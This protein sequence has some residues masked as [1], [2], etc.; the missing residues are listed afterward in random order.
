MEGFDARLKIPDNLYDNNGSILNKKILEH[1]DI[2][3]IVQIMFKPSEY[4]N[5]EYVMEKCEYENPYVRIIEFQQ[6]GDQIIG[7]IDDSNYNTHESPKF[8]IKFHRNNIMEIPFYCPGNENLQYPPLQLP[9]LTPE[10]QE[11]Q[12]HQADCNICRNRIIGIRYKCLGC[13]D[14]DMCHECFQLDMKG[15]NKHKNHKILTIKHA[16]VV[17]YIVSWNRDD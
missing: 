2:G 13:I 11:T 9:D 14:F 16:A 4:T 1:L 17:E 12:K 7:F 6:P 10:E 8:Y 5:Q 15:E 3:N